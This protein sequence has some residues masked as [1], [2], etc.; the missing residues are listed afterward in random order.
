MLRDELHL[1]LHALLAERHLLRELPRLLHRHAGLLHRHAGLLHRAHRRA[2]IA[3]LRWAHRHAGLGVHGL[4]L[5]GLR[6]LLWRLLGLLPVRVSL[7]RRRRDR[8]HGELPLEPLR[9]VVERQ[10]GP[11]QRGEGL[12]VA[13]VILLDRRAHGGRP[14][15]ERAHLAHP[16][17]ELDLVHRRVVVRVGRDDREHVRR[18][19][20]ED[21]ED[22]VQVRRALR[23]LGEDARIDDR[24]RQLLRRDEARPVDRGD[25]LQ[26]VPLLEH[27]ELDERVLD[28]DAVPAGVGD[29][30]PVLVA[31]DATLVQEAVSDSLVDPGGAGHVVRSAALDVAAAARSIPT[32]RSGRR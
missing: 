21:R 19:V 18:V 32:D 24:L 3:L 31:R 6:L 27:V 5:L 13:V 1:R 10:R 22:A 16:R 9:V 30:E 17:R 25:V 7:P 28:A 20:V 23:D 11:Q 4:L 12:R 8:V 29:R 2:R 14:R 15:D 26:E